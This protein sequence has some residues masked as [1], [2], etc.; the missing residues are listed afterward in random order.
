M[1]KGIPYSAQLLCW[2]KFSPGVFRVLPRTV[3]FAPAWQDR[4]VAAHF[5]HEGAHRWGFTKDW[6]KHVQEHSEA[7]EQYWKRDLK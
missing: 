1:S 2:A 5:R 3:P 7:D 4:R 6:D